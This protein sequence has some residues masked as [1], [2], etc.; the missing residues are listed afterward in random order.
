MLFDHP[1]PG[2]LTCFIGR[3]FFFN[4]QLLRT[5]STVGHSPE[6]QFM[7]SNFRKPRE[8]VSNREEI[9]GQT[10]VYGWFF[11]DGPWAVRPSD[12]TSVTGSR[13]RK[14]SAGNRSVATQGPPSC[15]HGKSSLTCRS[16]GKSTQ[17]M[18]SRMVPTLTR[19]GDGKPPL[20]PWEW[21]AIHEQVNIV[22]IGWC[23]GTLNRQLDEN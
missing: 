12:M 22:M 21:F 5:T 4:Y 23:F 8:S 19:S 20:V 6:C 18:K 16:M 7:M 11:Q 13:V 17:V 10:A 15:A 9:F 3:M 2:S 14:P 1:C